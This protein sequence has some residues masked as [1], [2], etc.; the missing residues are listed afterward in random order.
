V[1]QRKYKSAA[2]LST[3]LFRLSQIFPIMAPLAII[4]SPFRSGRKRRLP[5][6]AQPSMDGQSYQLLHVIMVNSGL[7]TAK[8]LPNKLK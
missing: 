7:T 1:K 5:T 4:F 6:F 8:R 2:S 3:T